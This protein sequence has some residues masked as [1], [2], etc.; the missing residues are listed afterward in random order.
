MKVKITLC[1]LSLFLLVNP[2]FCENRIMDSA[3]NT[4]IGNAKITVPKYNYST[5]SDAQG[6][7]DLGNIK[8]PAILSVEKEGYRPFSLT[9]NSYN[10]A[11]T[12]PL[13]VGI[14][15][16]D[17]SDIV[18]ESGMVH[19]GDDNYSTASANAGNFRL[20]SSGPYFTK[21]FVI[22]NALGSNYLVIG[23]ILGIDTLMAK[24][25]GQNRIVNA[26][27]S[28]PEVYF[29][30]AKIAEIQLNGDNQ[31]IKLP[32]NLVRSQ[33]KNQIT[34][35][36]GRNLMQTVYIDYDDIEIANLSILSD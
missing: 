8:S 1:I 10:Q 4:P 35:K 5:Y 33:Q 20:K 17:V 23:S 7:F 24:T 30:G 27:A 2:A 31:K 26:Y 36:A 32:N 15:K 29:N 9:V 18:I 34:I 14:E 3:T 28:P 16:S 13:V 19:I 12:K 6:N 25:M 22:N 11:G 21:D